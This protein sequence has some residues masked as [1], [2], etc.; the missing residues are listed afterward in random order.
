M[1]AVKIDGSSIVRGDVV[2]IP[3]CE[4]GC[5]PDAWVHDSRNAEA[6]PFVR[7]KPGP[8]NGSYRVAVTGNAG[9]PF[10]MRRK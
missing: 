10:V 2:E 8:D 4:C 3:L 6:H 7:M 9:K 5:T 1:G